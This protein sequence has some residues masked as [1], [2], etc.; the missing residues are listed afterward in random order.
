MRRLW[1]RVLRRLRL[2]AAGIKV[3]LDVPKVVLGPTGLGAS[4]Y[5]IHAEEL[6]PDSVVYSFGVG[7]DVHWDLEMI[8]RF[9]LTVHAFDPSPLSVEWVRSADLP[10]KFVFHPYGIGATDGLITLYPPP[11]TRT[12]HYS[13]INRGRA[14]ADKAVKVPVKR[15]ATIAAELGHDHIDVLKIDIDGGEYDV[16]PDVLASGIPIRQILMEVHHN[17]KTL[18]FND[19]R[20]MLRALRSHGYRILDISRRAREFSLLKT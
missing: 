14:P 12:V 17:F 15:L 9:E 8:D 11:T 6:G 10:E 3:E 1:Q 2:R 18:K 16:L 13:S 20:D 5:T 7:R 4:P 19:T